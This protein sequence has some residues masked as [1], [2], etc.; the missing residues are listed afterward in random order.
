MAQSTA[1]AVTLQN[2][3]N[4]QGLSQ[5]G[6]FVKME[7]SGGRELVTALTKLGN[8]RDIERVVQR[9]QQRALVPVVE[10]AKQ[11]A[12]NRTGALAESIAARPANV[13][14]HRDFDP[15]D[16]KP[17][18]VGPAGWQFYGQFVEFGTARIAARPF[19]RPAW[20]SN[21]DR[22]LQTHTKILANEIEKRAARLARKAAK[23]A[24]G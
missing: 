24:R 21:K 12:P 9:A 4:P 8:R 13:R 18:V 20:E 1:R 7:I 10:A 23:A 17:T 14:K 16:L 5:S 2:F 22:V 15:S 6:T 3:E 11:L 19:L